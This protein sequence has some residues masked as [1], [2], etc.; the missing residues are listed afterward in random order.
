[1]KKKKQSKPPT[2]IKLTVGDY[3]HLAALDKDIQ[4]AEAQARDH[5]SRASR[6]RAA[7]FKALAA[8]YPEL[9]ADDV[10]YTSN[11]A[12]CTLTRTG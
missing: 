7:L 3:W 6:K 11:D 5:I 2:V 1:M 8:K 10:A 9:E 4:I 12:A